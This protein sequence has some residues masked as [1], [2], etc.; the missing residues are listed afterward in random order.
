MFD[1]AS[2]GADFA[3]SDFIEGGS[4]SYV[5]VGGGRSRRKKRKLRELNNMD[6]VY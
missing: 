2:Y 4:S 1:T 5:A 6:L 3:N